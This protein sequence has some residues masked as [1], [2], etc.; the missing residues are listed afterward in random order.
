LVTEDGILYLYVVLATNLGL[1]I[2]NKILEL[3]RY[4]LWFE[5]GRGVCARDPGVRDDVKSPLSR[6][7][8]LSL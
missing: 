6:L 8:Y 1:S 3:K 7:Q 2:C 4:A 5:G